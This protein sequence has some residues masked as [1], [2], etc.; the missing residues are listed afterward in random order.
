MTKKQQMSKKTKTSRSK[1]YNVGT[2]WLLI[3][4]VLVLST[5]A[6]FGLY[7]LGVISL[8]FSLYDKS[9]N[10][11]STPSGAPAN[12]AGMPLDKD[13]FEAIPR[14]EFASALSKIQIPSEYYR[15]YKIAISS[16]SNQQVTEYF[17]IKKNDDWWVQTATGGVIMETAI[18]KQNTVT[19]ND[20]AAN[21]S[22]TLSG[23][24]LEE[25]S[26]IIALETLVDIIHNIA[27]GAPV[28]YGG[29]ITDYSLSFTQMPL[30]SENLFSFS[31]LCQ[32]GVR[33]EYAFSFENA[34]ILSASKS[35]GGKTIYKMEI[36]DYRNNLSEINTDGLF[37]A[38]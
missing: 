13:T 3:V 25:C 32:N 15:N 4:V 18:C 16:D 37:S 24:S 30:S 19:L 27:N 38:N 36:K 34:V 33:E 12:I 21:T 26:G 20:N 10:V 8:P 9:S 17:V 6:F 2:I 22:T 23:V 11:P 7:K 5:F 14:E 28:T 31:F 35:Y 1:F 29:G